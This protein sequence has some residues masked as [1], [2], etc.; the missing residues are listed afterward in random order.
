MKIL[1]IVESPTKQASI[2]GLLNQLDSNNQ[3][4]V[5]ATGGHLKTLADIGLYNFGID[6]KTYEGTYIFLPRKEGICHLLQDIALK[7]DHILIATDPDREGEAIAYSVAKILGVDP[8]S[9]CRIEF[10]EISSWALRQ[11][12]EAPRTINTN[13]VRSQE[14]RNYID[15]M[16]GYRL[17]DVTRQ[18]LHC[19]SAG[20]VQSV[21]LKL[22]VDRSQ[23]IENF[24]PQGYFP[25]YATFPAFEAK[26]SDVVDLEMSLPIAETVVANA[27][28][29][30]T[31]TQILKTNERRYPEKALSTSMML[32]K[33]SSFLGFTSKSTMK[34][35]QKLFEGINIKGHHVG[36]ITY[37]RTDST[38]LNGQFV[39]QTREYIKQTYGEQYVGS[40]LNNDANKGKQDAHEA[41]RPVNINLTPDEM[42]Q[43]LTDTEYK[44]YRLIYF[45]TLRAIFAPATYEKTILTLESHHYHFQVTSYLPQF[46]GYRHLLK[47]ESPYPL[48]PLAGFEEGNQLEASQVFYRAEATKPPHYFTE[49]TLIRELERLG[50]G[51][52]ST[53]ASFLDA[54]SRNGGIEFVGKELHPTEKGIIVNQGLDN[55]F[56]DYINTDYTRQMEE[57]LDAIELGELTKFEALDSFYQDF[58]QK[59]DYALKKMEVVALPEKEPPVVVEGIVC[60]LCGKPM[61]QRV[62]RR[63]KTKFVACSGFPACRYIV[64]NPHARTVINEKGEKVPK[65]PKKPGTKTKKR[66]TKSHTS[67][68]RPA[69]KKEA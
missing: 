15:K 49:S 18:K 34:T 46:E 48:F 47:E 1:V 21:T 59:V 65:N 60:P 40:Y 32:Q 26:Y 63:D 7:V 41:I 38:R 69:T 56:G 39:M 58:S 62:N 64:P 19:N 45:H 27:T 13:T 22:I 10:N 6:L 2:S 5:K 37:L 16:I 50:I 31:I 20:R 11:A 42:K 33:S 17:S 35:A 14:T 55:Y 66:K 53:Y 36:L 44:L 30:F 57:K 51:R 61:Y 67:S 68:S 52:P 43:H 24:V 9:I 29:P 25:V 28:N 3:Y 54:N 23:E 8:N 4:V 12:L